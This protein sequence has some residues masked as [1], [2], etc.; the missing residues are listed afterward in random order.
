MSGTEHTPGLDAFASA[1]HKKIDV[2]RDPDQAKHVPELRFVDRP[3]P[4]KY[5]VTKGIA[6]LNMLGREL[7]VAQTPLTRAELMFFAGD[8]KTVEEIPRTILRPGEV[9]STE[10]NRY[11]T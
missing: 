2:D 8:S 4:A 1:A 7:P 5:R 6:F 3:L 10:L 11:I 9:Y